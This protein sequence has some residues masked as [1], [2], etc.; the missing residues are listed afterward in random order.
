MSSFSMPVDAFMSTLNIICDVVSW[1]RLPKFE[2]LMYRH[3]LHR[4][5]KYEIDMF[6]NV[7]A[8]DV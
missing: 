7:D 8:M 1:G 6:R 4:H 5:K 3:V 2:Y